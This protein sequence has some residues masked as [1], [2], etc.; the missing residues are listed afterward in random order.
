MAEDPYTL[1]GVAR[2]ASPDAIRAAYR[3]LARQHHP[4]LN[5]GNAAAEARF[6]AIA[7]AHDLLSDADKRARFDRGEIDAHG[8]ETPPQP[9]YRDYAESAQGRR[10]EA[11]GDAPGYGDWTAQTFEDLFGAATR[12]RTREGTAF[13]LRG[14][15]V[16]YALRVSFLDAVLGATTRLAMPDG[17]TLDVKVPPGTLSGQVLRL[18]GQGGP[19]L[20][21][22][23]AGDA[24]IEITVAPHAFFRRDGQTIRLDLPVTLHE[25]VLGARITV[26]TPAGPVSMS[27]PAGSDTGQVLRLRGRGVPAHGGLPAGDLLA[28]LSVVLGP[29]DP[30]LADFLRD[31]ARPDAPDPRAAMLGVP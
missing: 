9:R 28:T 10:Y 20:N 4:D 13:K 8:Q 5:P 14:H 31:H 1:L 24:L 17:R 6:K 18:A 7:A 23:P 15:D 29:P 2:D 21:G 11:A 27:V 26:P 12:G 19:G 3:K 22:G 30:A 25:A 16:A